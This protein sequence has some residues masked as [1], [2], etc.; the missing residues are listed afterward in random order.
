ML[1][2]LMPCPY[3]SMCHTPY[4]VSQAYSLQLL[5]AV[6]RVLSWLA[7]FTFQ[8][9]AVLQQVLVLNTWSSS[10]NSTS[11]TE[12]GAPWHAPDRPDRV[13][14]V[15]THS[16]VAQHNDGALGSTQAQP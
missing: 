14:Q 7:H 6:A 8:R 15:Y 5:M 16:H 2:L 4:N 1:P 3:R 12:W 13:G 10:A 9:A 11:Q